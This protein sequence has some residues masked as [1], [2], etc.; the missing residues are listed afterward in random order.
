MTE[1]CPV[2]KAWQRMVR[3]EE[4]ARPADDLFGLHNGPPRVDLKS[5]EVVPID[6]ATAKAIILKYE[7]LK[8]MPAIVRECFGIYFDGHC[9][10]VAVFGDEYS[11]NLG[12]WNEY[13]FTGK[14]R[15]LARGAC[16][17]WAHPHTASRLIM[18][19]IKMLPQEIEVVTATVDPEAGEIGTIY[20][21][22]SWHYVGVMRERSGLGPMFYVEHRGKRYSQNSLHRALGTEKREVIQEAMPGCRIVEYHGKGRYFYFRKNRKTHR[23]AIEHLI[24]PYPKRKMQ[25]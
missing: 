17:H 4:A 10:G 9:G 25:A 16:V 6:Y 2:G 11:E 1:T 18:S 5:A 13:G 7:W 24:T 23:R 22:C 20:Q 19:A 12:H 14:M 15:L 3:E 21:A 8:S